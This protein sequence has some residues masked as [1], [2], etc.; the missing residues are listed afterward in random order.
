MFDEN[1]IVLT[2]STPKSHSAK[3]GLVINKKDKKLIHFERIMARI[4]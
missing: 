2:P 1:K 4:L 3:K